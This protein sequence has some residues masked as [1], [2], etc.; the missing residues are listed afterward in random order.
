MRCAQVKIV[1]RK[2]QKREGSMVLPALSKVETI[3]DIYI[4]FFTIRKQPNNKTSNTWWP[5]STSGSIC[6]R[7]I[8]SSFEGGGGGPRL[9]ALFR[10]LHTSYL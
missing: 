10:A 7:L 3:N 8:V 6:I 5:A 2:A 9:P 1:K 4:T